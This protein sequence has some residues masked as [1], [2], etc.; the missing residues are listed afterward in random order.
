MEDANKFTKDE[1]NYLWRDETIELTEEEYRF[2]MRTSNIVLDEVKLKPF[3]VLKDVFKDIPDE[4]ENL[5]ISQDWESIKKYVESGQ[6]TL[7]RLLNFIDNKINEDVIKRKL[8]NTT[9]FNLLSLIL[10]IIAEKKEEIKTLPNG[11]DSLINI[12]ELWNYPSISISEMYRYPFN[13]PPENLAISLKWLKDKRIVRQ[14]Y[15][16]EAIKNI[17]NVEV[18]IRNKEL[19]EFLKKFVAAFKDD[20]DTLKEIK[21][22]FS[23]IL[24]KNSFFYNDFKDII[25]S[26]AVKYLLDNNFVKQIIPTLSE[27]FNN[28]QTQE[29]VEIIKSLNRYHILDNESIKQFID[30]CFN[31]ISNTGIHQYH[32]SYQNYNNYQNYN[33]AVLNFWLKAV[34][35]VIG[36]IKDINLHNNTYNN[37]SSYHRFLFSAYNSQYLNEIQVETYKSYIEI[38]GEF[39]LLT[40][41][42]QYKK[43]IITWLKDF[44]NPIH[45]DVYSAVNEVY[46]K[47]IKETEDWQQFAQHLINHFINN[48]TDWNYKKIIIDTINEMLLISDENKGLSSQQI[49]QILEQYLGLYINTNN[50]EVKN[51]II[52][53]SKKEFMGSKV[54]ECV[55]GSYIT[56][57]TGDK[58]IPI[59]Y[60]LID[61]YGFDRFYPKV[62]E[63]LASTELKKQKLGVK[64]VDILN[65]KIPN[66]MKSKIKDLLTE[67]KGEE[68]KEKINMI[69]NAL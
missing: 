44:L 25:E 23:E 9:G 65:E 33:W 2:F 16:I 69:M 49:E 37:I 7:E 34:I 53:I 32:Q 55:I 24:L 26:E 51:H 18:F 4:V 8:Y 60:E 14:L 39:Y 1:K 56:P 38:L 31:K 62:R 68:L 64:F 42:T 19:I 15:I 36:K 3:F 17:I 48:Q 29:K 28:N 27:N 43:S 40:D 57:E 22:K 12:K 5:V 6:I 20:S 47:I 54:I 66:D 45:L 21:G 58:I 67:I 13:Q 30:A 59:I 41:N 10:K 63:L 35:D 52:K 11:I 50:D 61:K 46:R